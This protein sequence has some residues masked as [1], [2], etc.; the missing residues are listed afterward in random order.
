MENV[1]MISTNLVLLGLVE[2]EKLKYLYV[3]ISLGTYLI[4]VILCSTIVFVIWTETSLHEPMHIFI[5]NL[6]L[7]GMF[8]STI[9]FPKLLTDLGSGS[10]IISFAGCLVQ[11]FCMHTFAAVELFTFTIMAQDRYI[12]VGQPLR[13]AT[14]MTNGKALK[15]I[16]V[17]WLIAIIAVFVPVV[18]TS[19][20]SLCGININN[21]FCDNMSLIRLACGDTSVNNIFGAVEAFFINISALLMVI[22]CYIQTFRI[23]LKISKEA[24]Q[25]AV[26]TLVTHL[27]AFSNYMVATLF[28][29]LRYRLNSNALSINGHILF[30]VT[31]FVTPSIVNPLIYGI[32]TEALKIKIA[33]KL[34]KI[35]DPHDLAKSKS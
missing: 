30:S 32:R 2:M 7:N 34:R 10:K 31:G 4:T 24:H 12:A 33:Q 8:G 5:C 17:I 35:S 26:R 6:L 11:S 1:S 21:V 3:V 15:Y 27:V 14:L 23:C 19:Q 29:L 16:G 22:Y 18:M 25:K 9:F 28:L 13:Y 20:L